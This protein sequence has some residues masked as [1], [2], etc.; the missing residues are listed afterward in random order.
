MLLGERDLLQGDIAVEVEGAAGE[1]ADLKLT[2]ETGGQ[3][4]LLAADRNHRGVD[5]YARLVD[6]SELTVVECLGDE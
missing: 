6:Q 1:E 5:H 2:T 3:F 4:Q